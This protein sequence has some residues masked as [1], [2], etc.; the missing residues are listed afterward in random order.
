MPSSVFQAELPA[1][2][3]LGDVANLAR[4]FGTSITATAI[5]CAQFRTICVFGVN[6][7]RVTWGYGGIRPGAVLYL[8]DQV[9]DAV[10]AVMAR[11]VP[12]E[13][14]YFYANGYRGGHHRF[15]WIRSGADS[16]VFMLT[17][18]QARVR[19]DK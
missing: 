19:E 9:R 6:G 13:E 17:P 5:R 3:T 1:T 12:Q 18:T 15:D 8:L 11:E 10:Q 16:G 7:D 2:L 4:I 14:V